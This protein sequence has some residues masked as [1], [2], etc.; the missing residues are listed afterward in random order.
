MPLGDGDDEISCKFAVGNNFSAKE[1]YMGLLTEDTEVWDEKLVW[2][3]E[4]P[5]KV[6]F[7]IWSAA[8][9]AI[10]TIDNLRRRGIVFINK[11][12][13]CNMSEESARHLLLHCPTTMAVWNYFIKAAN[14]QWVQGNNI[15]GVVF[16]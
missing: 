13:V 10:P 5:S 7:F 9:N 2:R 1:C 12:Y 15:L 16:T 4:I 6:S 3:K 8:R 11:C 14:M